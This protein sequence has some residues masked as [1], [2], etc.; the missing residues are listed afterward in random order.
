MLVTQPAQSLDFHIQNRRGGEAW[1][2]AVT[3]NPPI[4]YAHVNTPPT[5]PPADIR[6]RIFGPAALRFAKTLGS[7]LQRRYDLEPHVAGKPSAIAL[8]DFQAPDSMVWSREAL[9]GYL[10]G[11]HAELTEIE[12]K[13]VVT[14]NIVTHL[15]GGAAFRAGLFRDGE[16]S[17]LSA[18]ISTNACTLGKFNRVGVSAGTATKGLRYV[19]IGKL[20]DRT[21]GALDGI[22]F[23]LDVVSAEYRALWPQGYEPWSAE[24]EVFHNPFA[25]HPISR[26]FIPEAQH[27]FERNGEM[28]CAAHYK[29]SVLWS[30][31]LIQEAKT[32][33]PTLAD[34]Q[35]AV[36]A[37]NIE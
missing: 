31:T 24:L 2:E 30:K 18:V 12:G 26:E 28:I 16:H 20:F 23:C 22:S 1:V 36:D 32:P 5:E 10:Y 37:D 35:Q 8:A 9:I 29:T 7:K 33:M 14:A 6:E 21:P 3:A 15:L 17:E 19:R 25:K 13:R 4:R 11:M 27:W 34:F